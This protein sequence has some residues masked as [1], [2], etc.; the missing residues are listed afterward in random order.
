M[1]FESNLNKTF[2]FKSSLLLD[3]W[4]NRSIRTPEIVMVTNEVNN[5]G[6]N[7][8]T[9]LGWFIINDLKAINGHW[10]KKIQII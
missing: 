1:D 5:L 7:F 4:K 2:S 10:R 6:N 8:I 3:I 9:I